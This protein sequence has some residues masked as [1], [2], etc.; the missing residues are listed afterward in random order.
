MDVF[1]KPYRKKAVVAATRMIDGIRPK[2]QF[3]PDSPLEGTGF[4]PPV[5]R[6]ERNESRSGTGTVTE[7]TKIR[8]EAVAPG[9]DGSNPF[10][11][12]GESANPGYSL[13]RTHS[14]ILA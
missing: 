2:S 1:L 8:R 10:P 3:A 12:T 7:A 9:T 6:R 13:R 5:P 14:R 11:S 4:E